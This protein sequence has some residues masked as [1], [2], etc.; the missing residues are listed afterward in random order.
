QIN[1]FASEIEFGILRGK[2]MREIAR[3]SRAIVTKKYVPKLNG[4]RRNLD[5]AAKSAER[6]PRNSQLVDL[7][8][9]RATGRFRSTGDVQIRRQNP[10]HRVLEPEQRLEFLHGSVLQVQ[11]DINRAGA[12]IQRSVPQCC[13]CRKSR[14]SSTAFQRAAL[15]I[16]A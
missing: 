11:C 3:Q 9:P 8:A 5:L 1:V 10:G 6:L 7:H 13:G 16:D 2:V 4:V 12:L 14:R 15:Q